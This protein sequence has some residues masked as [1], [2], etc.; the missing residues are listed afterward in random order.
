[1]NKTV[2]DLFWSASIDELKKGYIYDAQ[3]EEYACLVCG[4]RFTNGVVYQHGNVLYEA[5]KYT[6]LHIAERH[7][8]MLHYLLTLDKKLTGLTDLQ[9]ELLL[10][11]HE[12]RSDNEILKLMGGGSASTIRNH[13][14]T[15]REKM[16]QAKLFLALMELAESKSD[17]RPKFVHAHRTAT[18]VDERYAVTEEER[19]KILDQYFTEGL[20]GPISE[21]PKKEK[22]KIVILT[23]L[24]QRFD[25]Q[26]QYTEKEVNEILKTAHDEEYVT[27]RRYLIEYG[28]MDRLPDGSAYWVMK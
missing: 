12:D 2:L 19:A 21:F 27:L 7:T 20:D 9:K 26:K 15:L 14:F 24:M 22:R 3:A 11:F 4:E 6:E 1:M 5:K 23:H 25:A 13:R 17:Q 8:S 28:F 18:M 16:K 10:H